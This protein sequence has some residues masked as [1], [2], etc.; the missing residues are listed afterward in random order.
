MEHLDLAPAVA[1]AFTQAQEQRNIRILKIGVE[2]DTFL[3]VTKTTPYQGSAEDD[4][5]LLANS[6]VEEDKSA[7]ILYCLSNL[8]KILPDDSPKWLVITWIPESNRC[9]K[10]DKM[11]LSTSAR[12]IVRSLGVKNIKSEYSANTLDQLTWISYTD[13]LTAKFDT[14]MLT[15]LEDETMD[16]KRK[17]TQSV[18]PRGIGCLVFRVDKSINTALEKFTQTDGFSWVEVQ[19]MTETVVEET[20]SLAQTVESEHFTSCQALLHAEPRLV[21]TRLPHAAGGTKTVFVLYCPDHTSFQLKISLATSKPTL[22]ALAAELGLS[23]DSFVEAQTVEDVDEYLLDTISK[24]SQDVIRGENEGHLGSGTLSGLSGVM[25][26]KKP[27]SGAKRKLLEAMKPK[28]RV[29]LRKTVSKL[30]MASRLYR[31]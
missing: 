17:Q 25:L 12:Q 1:T 30:M 22:V 16:V 5:S 31:K 28:P 23:F 18:A 2:H 9:S 15:P 4:F 8:G 7:V 6:I 21:I 24:G 26:H 14:A 10:S 20:L 29:T 11:F 27:F 19:L 13:S 3:A